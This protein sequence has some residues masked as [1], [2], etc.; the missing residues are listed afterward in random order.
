MLLREPYGGREAAA[1]AGGT[2]KPLWSLPRGRVGSRCRRCPL[3]RRSYAV[4]DTAD[5]WACRNGL[6]YD[7]PLGQLQQGRCPL[8]K[9]MESLIGVSR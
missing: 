5:V 6:A 2:A 4:A 8:P 7:T 1:D 3:A 9:P